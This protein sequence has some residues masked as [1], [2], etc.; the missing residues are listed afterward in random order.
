M[1]YGD[2]LV[3]EREIYMDRQV[4]R[5][6]HKRFFCYDVVVGKLFV[7]TNVEDH[8]R[9]Q[10]QMLTTFLKVGGQI[11]V[12]EVFWTILGILIGDSAST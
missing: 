2:H 11:W 9:I 7:F 5:M 1:L 6:D 8:Y 4:P 3:E 12:L 10:Y